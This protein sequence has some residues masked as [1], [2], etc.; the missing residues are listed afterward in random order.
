[1]VVVL[2]ADSEPFRVLS[3][4]NDVDAGPDRPQ[5]ATRLR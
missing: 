3:W 1:V 4:Q 5:A 2:G